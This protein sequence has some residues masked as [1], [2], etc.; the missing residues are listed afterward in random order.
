MR[1]SATILAVLA[2]ACTGQSGNN[3]AGNATNGTNAAIPAPAP[4]PNTS[5]EANS[6]GTPPSVYDA[7][8]QHT[9]RGT[10]PFWSLTI[11]NGQMTYTPADGTG[12]SEPTPSSSPITN[13][14][15]FA[16]ANLTVRFTNTPC[17]EASGSTAPYTVQV[18]V[19]T[20]TLNGC[21]S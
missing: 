11:A 3:A 9:A 17:E 19:G 12:V 16:T 10:E 14:F 15:E 2:A 13:G 18:L 5:S 4:A 1:F 20:Q 21:G 8:A 6:A 7:S